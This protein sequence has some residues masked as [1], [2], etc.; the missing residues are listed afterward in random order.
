MIDAKQKKLEELADVRLGHPFRGSFPD[1]PT[2]SVGV[3]QMRDLTSQGV[4]DWSSI[5]RTEIETRK[6]LEWLKAG[7]ILFASRGTSNYAGC[8]RDVPLQVVC[9]PHLYVITVRNQQLV[10]PEFIAWQI[11][12]MASQ[13]Y[14]KQ[15]A[16]GS[17]QLSVRRAVLENLPL[18]IPSIAHQQ[19]L[20]A[21]DHATRQE[22]LALEALIRN[23][24]KQVE[25]LAAALLNPPNS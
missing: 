20:L 22:K 7:D 5:R 10:L 23:R 25:A 12:R 16:E 19:R 2:G 21:L 24:E 1:L 3:V 9:S 11:N 18:T 4:L 13:R 8:L 14:L 15:S 6:E 17:D